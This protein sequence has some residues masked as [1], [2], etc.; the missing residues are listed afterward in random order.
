MADHRRSEETD[1]IIARNMR[2]ALSKNGLSRSD[3]GKALGLTPSTMTRKLSGEIT[4]S[5]YDIKVASRI[6]GVS[7]NSFFDAS[8]SV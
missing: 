5:A 1:Q 3:F 8:L 7:M 4:W 2:A 6:F